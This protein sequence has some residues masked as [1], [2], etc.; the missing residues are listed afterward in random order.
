MKEHYRL[1]RRESYLMDLCSRQT[2]EHLGCNTRRC[3]YLSVVPSLWG[4]V[5]CTVTV[6]CIIMPSC[7][8]TQ[9]WVCCLSGTTVHASEGII[10]LQKINR[11]DAEILWLIDVCHVMGLISDNFMRDWMT[12]YA[13]ASGLTPVPLLPHVSPTVSNDIMSGCTV[14]MLAHMCFCT[15]MVRHPACM[16]AQWWTSAQ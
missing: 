12:R 2:V 5:P 1:F 7:H 10:L 8:H 3:M 4:L 13:P 6:Q 16:L 14:W 11:C 15:V 9:Q